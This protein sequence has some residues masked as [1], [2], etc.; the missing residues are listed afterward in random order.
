[1]PPPD[2]YREYPPGLLKLWHDAMSRFWGGSLMDWYTH[3]V[4]H[5]MIH[6]ALLRENGVAPRGML[7]AGANIGHLLW[8]W[9]LLGF[10]R[11]LMIEPQQQPF[12]KLEWLSKVSSS[13]LLSYEDFL[14]GATNTQIQLAQCAVGERDGEAEL[15][16]VSNSNMS[17]LLRPYEDKL[18]EQIASSGRSNADAVSVVEQ[19][20]VPVVTLDSLLGALGSECK[21]GDY[22]VLYMNIQGGELQALRGATDVLRH[23][24]LI[25]LENNFVA[26]YEGTPS[27]EELDELLGEHG[28][29]AVWG[30]KHSRMGTGFTAY[31]K[32][33]EAR[34]G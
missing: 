32:T 15:Y 20:T 1:M 30:Q 5:T 3:L 2:I 27:A 26:R 8:V 28:F 9:I 22:N 23:L 25:Y 7:Y 16:V 6:G 4:Q 12:E 29:R 34:R 13:I 19:I 14:P 24:E 11:V 10:D 33:P 18:R 17:S 21:P 31:A